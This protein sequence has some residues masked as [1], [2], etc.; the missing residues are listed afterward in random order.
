MDARAAGGAGTNQYARKGT[1]RRG[2]QPAYAVPL[3]P[4]LVR[5]VMLAVSTET[6]RRALG[7]SLLRDA[8]GEIAGMFP[9]ARY[10][11]LLLKRD[12]EPFWY[13][14][15]VL[16]SHEDPAEVP[17]AILAMLQLAGQVWEPDGGPDGISGLWNV[18]L[19]AVERIDQRIDCTGIAEYLGYP[20][21]SSTQYALLVDLQAAARLDLDGD[22]A[23]CLREVGI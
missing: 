8:V 15:Q 10:A 18:D 9:D 16:D 6:L 12:H 11:R 14:G 7:R 22:P 1:S 23:G 13:L 3:A 19:Q 4:V 17:K 5:Q 21:C 20:A 2:T